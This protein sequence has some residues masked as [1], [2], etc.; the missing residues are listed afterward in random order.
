MNLASVFMPGRWATRGITSEPGG[1]LNE[2]R[3]AW[4][5]RRRQKDAEGIIAKWDE[6][7]LERLVASRHWLED[8]QTGNL[9]R[10]FA[11][12]PNFAG[13]VCAYYL[14]ADGQPVMLEPHDPPSR[15]EFEKRRAAREQRRVD[16][17]AAAKARYEALRKDASR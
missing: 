17:A 3:Q 1:T 6:I 4:R 12:D 13:Q 9:Y 11:G 7:P 2:Q 5:E 14:R 15:E 8:T 16:Q 10:E